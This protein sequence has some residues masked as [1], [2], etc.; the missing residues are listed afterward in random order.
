MLGVISEDK[1]WPCFFQLSRYLQ[2][3]RYTILEVPLDGQPAD[4]HDIVIN[5][6]QW[7]QQTNL[8]KLLFYV[9]PGVA[10]GVDELAWC[11]QHLS[12]LTTINLGSGTHFIQEDYPHQIGQNLAE[13][14]EK[15]EEAAGEYVLEN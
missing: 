9:S 11:K 7:L 1:P 15:I 10:I 4:V 8:P 14:Y 3:E 6:N 12:N 13:W 2:K 5:F